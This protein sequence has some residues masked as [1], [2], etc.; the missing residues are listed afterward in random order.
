MFSSAE[1]IRRAFLRVGLL[2]A[3][4]VF[5]VLETDVLLTQWIS[6]NTSGRFIVGTAFLL[7]GISLAVFVVLAGIGLGV[8][9]VLDWAVSRR[10]AQAQGRLADRPPSGLLPT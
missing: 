7:A 6:G 4:M 2:A 3:I 8:A 1:G 10:R 5:V 9:A